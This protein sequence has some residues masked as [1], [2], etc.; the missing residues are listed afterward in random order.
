MDQKPFYASKT[1]WF[2]F[3]LG[4][5]FWAE[6]NLQ[7]LGGWL[8]VDVIKVLSIVL[9]VGNLYLRLITKDQITLKNEETWR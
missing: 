4:V 6:V 1:L 2:N 8:P 9:P 5:L 3:I 7:L